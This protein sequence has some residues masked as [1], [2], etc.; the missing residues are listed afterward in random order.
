MSDPPRGSI[1]EIL[2]LDH[3]EGGSHPCRFVV[4]GRVA[5]ANKQR[6]VVDSWCDPD[7]EQPHQADNVTR[8]TIVRTA[9][10]RITLLERQRGSIG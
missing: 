3:A 4:Y 2:F 10:E 9:I 6:I 5:K 8:F 7:P 1:V